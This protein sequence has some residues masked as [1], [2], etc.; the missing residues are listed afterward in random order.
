MPKLLNKSTNT[1]EYIS[2]DKLNDAVASG[3]YAGLRGENYVLSR[4]GKPL[5]VDGEAL[6]HVLTNPS[7]PAY[8]ESTGNVAALGYNQGR[9]DYLEGEEWEA[10]KG[11]ALSSVTFGVSDAVLRLSEGRE[12]AEEQAAIRAAN[13]IASGVGTVTGMLGPQAIGKIAGKTAGKGAARA[14]GGSATAA[15]L[16]KAPSALALSAG[17]AIAAKGAGKG[18]G[19]RI[20]AEAAGGAF[21]GAAFSAG[22]FVSDVALDNKDLT[23]EGFVSS[24]GSGALFGGAVGAALPIGGAIAGKGKKGLD[25]IFGRGAKEAGQ[26]IDNLVANKAK[27]EAAVLAAKNNLDEVLTRELSYYDDLVKPLPAAKPG[28]ALSAADD[29]VKVADNAVASIDDVR[30]A[31]VLP[32]ETWLMDNLN[33]LVPDDAARESIKAQA[34]ELAE[35][36]VSAQ[37]WLRSTRKSVSNKID[38]RN[39]RNRLKAGTDDIRRIETKEAT[40]TDTVRGFNKSDDYVNDY[41]QG[42]SRTAVIDDAAKAEIT[43][44]ITK[45]GD[46]EKAAYRLSKELTARWERSGLRPTAALDKHVERVAMYEKAIAEAKRLQGMDRIKHLDRLNDGALMNPQTGELWASVDE[47]IAAHTPMIDDVAKL[48]DDAA[49]TPPAQAQ[50][51]KE[52]LRAQNRRALQEERWNYQRAKEMRKEDIKGA[53]D[54]VKSAERMDDAVAR[55]MQGKSV[56]RGASNGADIDTVD[57]LAVSEMMGL[58]GVRSEDI[59]VIGPVV[60]AYLKFRLLKHGLGKVLGKQSTGVGTV[61]SRAASARNKIH[62][63]VKKFAKAAGKPSRAVANARTPLAIAALR[64]PLYDASRERGQREDVPANES[65]RLF[66][67][68]S[69]EIIAAM[70]DPQ[71][72]RNQ[73]AS[74]MPIEDDELREKVADKAIARLQFLADKM[75]QDPRLRSELSYKWKPAQKDI[76]KF[77]RYVNAAENPQSVFDDLE[78]GRVSPEAAETLQTLYPEMYQEAQQVLLEELTNRKEPLPLRHRQRMSILFDVVLDDS[79][80]PE[81]VAAVQGAFVKQESPPESSIRAKADVGSMYE[82]GM[83]RRA[84]K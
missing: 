52:E 36:K 50:L 26:S 22:Q 5:T 24:I 82:L 14:I 30:V 65:R 7:A 11:A 66:A 77:A 43:E 76:R 47:A 33:A 15:I 16:G 49:L 6:E 48:A 42:R 38:A 75:P 35:K 63:A 62:S 56:P 8:A 60:S 20:L 68:R 45:L 4:D 40:F 67:K 53:K 58:L 81:F 37:E 51:T 31:E 18:L 25:K 17:S 80:R 54:A 32:E 23:A 79:M 55:Q 46:Y 9:Q 19:K 1:V 44:A 73:L 41:I 3:A 69:E 64:E 83:Q 39:A 74:A 70:A 57:V 61:A 78:S 59:P 10:F 27:T 72:T 2:Q 13:P 29:A 12:A 34:R 28:S 21:E 71:R 84:S